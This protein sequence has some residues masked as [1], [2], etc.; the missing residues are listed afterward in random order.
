MLPDCSAVVN[1]QLR[2]LNR[3]RVWLVRIGSIKLDIE[4]CDLSNT[5]NACVPTRARSR[6]VSPMV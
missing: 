3:K 4:H 5:K 1:T 6:A 2:M